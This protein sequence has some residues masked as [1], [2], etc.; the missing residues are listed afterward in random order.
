VALNTKSTL[1][2][3]HEPAFSTSRFPNLHVLFFIQCP[4]VFQT[5]SYQEVSPLNFGVYLISQ[6]KLRVQPHDLDTFPL[7][8]LGHL[9]KSQCSSLCNIPGL[10][11]TIMYI[12]LITLISATCSAHDSILNFLQ[13]RSTRRTV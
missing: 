2:D 6:S 3:D 11:T 10:V 7:S 8:I 5:V 1:G 4:L 12:F 9:Y 13:I